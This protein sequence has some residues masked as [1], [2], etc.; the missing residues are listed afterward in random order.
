MWVSSQVHHAKEQARRKVGPILFQR[1]ANSDLKY[2]NQA[3]EDEKVWEE[4]H[5]DTR[6][7]MRDSLMEQAKLSIETSFQDKLVSRTV[8]DF[9]L[10]SKV[11]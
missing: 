2:R 9:N 3:E 4:R 1:E 11:L 6:T 7:F 8:Y 5:N 10:Y